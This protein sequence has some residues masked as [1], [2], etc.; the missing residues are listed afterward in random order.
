MKKS[1]LSFQHKLTFHAK[2][3][4]EEAGRLAQFDQ[5]DTISIQHCLLALF[6]EK[7]SLGSILLQ[8]I[9]F[10]ADT[11]TPLC[12]TMPQTVLPASIPNTSPTLSTEVK[13]IVRRAYAI[14]NEF[15]YPYVGTE[16]L[17]YSLMETESPV[18]DNIFDTLNI[19]DEKIEATLSSHMK[20]G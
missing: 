1:T 15:Q 4:L 2:H 9:G 20:L 3:A 13:D 6:L 18:L 14:A 10:Q 19:D 16:H 11:L 8:S 5:A 7:G 17:V 12:V